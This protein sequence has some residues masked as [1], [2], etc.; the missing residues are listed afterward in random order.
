MQRESAG[1]RVQRLAVVGDP[2]TDHRCQPGGPDGVE[3]AE[4]QLRRDP[5][6]AHPREPRVDR[7]GS[8]PRGADDEQRRVPGPAEEVGQEREGLL[9]APLHVV[10]HEQQGPIDRQDRAREPLDE[11]VPPPGVRHGAGAVGELRVRAAVAGDQPLHLETPDGVEPLDGRPHARH[12]QPVGHRG[13]REAVGGAVAARLRHD[14]GALTDH[15]GELG[16]QAALAHTRLTPHEHQPR[17]ARDGASPGP[18][19][20]G[21]LGLPADERGRRAGPGHRRLRGRPGHGG[22]ARHGGEDPPRGRVRCHAELV[23][24]DRRAAL[25]GAHR[26]GA[27]TLGELQLHERPVAR[28]LQRSQPD[29][30][31]RDVHRRR[32]VAGARQGRGQHAAQPGTAALAVL[33]D[34]AHPVVV[35]AGEER[36]AVLRE[37]G[38][39]VRDHRAGVVAGRGVL[40]HPRVAVEEAE[41]DVHLGDV[42]PREAVGVGAHHRRV[43]ERVAQVVQLAT[44]VREGLGVGGVGPEE[45]GQAR[46][47]CDRAGVRHEVGDQ[48]DP[49]RRA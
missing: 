11:P 1:D 2:A 39:S 25:V 15:R 33:A 17:L 16:D 48:R 49:A 31:A 36:S 44:E 38:R 46:P 12:P 43:V 30:A 21:E 27:V 47:R 29:P 28:L 23:A 41:V 34:L 7:A 32:R 24:E 20:G 45:G 13:Q 6:R 26:P 8:V 4:S 42:L 37:R 40:R 5:G 3:R 22:R 18:D 19:Q 14:A 10:Q 35:D 9:V